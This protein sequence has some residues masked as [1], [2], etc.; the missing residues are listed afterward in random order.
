M[1]VASYYIFIALYG[2]NWWID[3]MPR[4]ILEFDH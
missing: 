3:R 2:I 1:P 4:A